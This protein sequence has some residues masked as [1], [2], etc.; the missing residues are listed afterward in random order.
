MEIIK[1]D[2]AGFCFGVR[3]AISMAEQSVQKYGRCCSLGS[4][5]HNPQEID[6]LKKK[7]F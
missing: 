4:L 1:A 3:R 5:I 6:R 7:T 2:Y